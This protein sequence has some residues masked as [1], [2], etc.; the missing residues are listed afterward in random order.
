[1]KYRK[2]F[3]VASK[4]KGNIKTATTG[5]LVTQISLEPGK[6]AI[7]ILNK[8]SS[9]FNYNL[10][11]SIPVPILGGNYTRSVGEQAMIHNI[12]YESKASVL[13]KSGDSIQKI[14]KFDFNIKVS[15][16]NTH[17][18]FEYLKVGEKGV[19]ISPADMIRS[20]IGLYYKI[21]MDLVRVYLN[22]VLVAGEYG[23]KE[24]EEARRLTGQSTNGNS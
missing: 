13:N 15:S 6:R 20:M 14:L 21:P 22:G 19:S 17:P 18:F 16:S 24:V 10:K 11:N 3:V 7:D 8:E 1:M 5:G 2:L 12:N 23:S 4:V 9:K